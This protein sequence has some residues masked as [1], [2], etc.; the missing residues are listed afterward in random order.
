LS[1]SWEPGPGANF[2]RS[3][4]KWS[5]GTRV[6]FD[7][8]NDNNADLLSVSITGD[9]LSQFGIEAT[10][11]LLRDLLSWGGKCSRI[12]IPIDFKDEHSPVGLIDHVIASC[13]RGELCKARKYKLIEQFTAEGACTGRTIYLGSR[14]KS[15]SGRYVRVYDKGLESGKAEAGHH[16]RFEVEFKQEPAQ[17]VAIALASSEAWEQEAAA[18]ALG[19]VSFNE[20]TGFASLLRRPLVEWWAALIDGLTVK[21]AKVKR[22]PTT[23]D[24]YLAW[25][26]DVIVPR[27]DD[28]AKAT[29]QTR[30]KVLD[31]ICTQQDRSRPAGGRNPVV[32]QFVQMLRQ[33]QLP[34]NVSLPTGKRAIL[35]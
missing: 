2:Y 33:H 4:R 1:D 26:N 29:S 19:A 18:Y 27:L 3:S 22:V 16:E 31:L 32:K 14:A 9:A 5:C 10:L 28:M 24:A 35:C 8:V 13:H 21:T 23:L 20:V 30:Q 34:L 25:I 7:G 12:D 15:G 6:T 17:L 11:Q